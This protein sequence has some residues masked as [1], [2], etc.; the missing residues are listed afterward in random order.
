MACL[1]FYDINFCCVDTV[2]A[3]G[4][5]RI[6][7]NKVFPFL[8]FVHVDLE[9]GDYMVDLEFDSSRGYRGDSCQQPLNE[10]SPMGFSYFQKKVW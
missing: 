2:N 3:S 1:A 7:T 10:Y 8:V 9:R 5:Q 6:L 4:Q